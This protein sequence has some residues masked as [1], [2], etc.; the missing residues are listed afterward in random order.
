MNEPDP[1]EPQ[2]A[3]RLAYEEAIRWR[4]EL[5]AQLDRIRT[6]AMAFFAVAV[7]AA[8]TGLAGFPTTKLPSSSPSVLWVSMI[9]AGVLANLAA[10]LAV[11]RSPVAPFGDSPRQMVWWGP[12]PHRRCCVPRPRS[13][14]RQKRPRAVPA[15]QRPPVLALCERDGSHRRVGGPRRAALGQAVPLTVTPP[16][17]GAPGPPRNTGPFPL[18]HTPPSLDQHES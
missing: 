10:V 11:L 15:G 2:V 16:P 18:L 17:S 3:Y 12:V 8:G 4:A 13:I 14:G 1:P 6:R 7:L 9:G 5:D